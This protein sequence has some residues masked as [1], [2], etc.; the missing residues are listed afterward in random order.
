MSKEEKLME[1]NRRMSELRKETLDTPKKDTQ[2]RLMILG[3]KQYIQ[4]KIDEIEGK[5]KVR[6]AI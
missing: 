5:Y 3:D 1:L 4:G 6:F 2:K